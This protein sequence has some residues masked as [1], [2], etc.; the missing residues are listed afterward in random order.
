MAAVCREA[1]VTVK[2]E[3]RLRDLNVQVS[4]TDE[5]RVG[6]L[7]DYLPCRQGK[8][9]AIDVTLRSPVTTLGEPRARAAVDLVQH[10]GILEFLDHPD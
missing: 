10:F 1:G 9:L 4:A 3:V 7:A 8:Q 2:S 6:V 5:H